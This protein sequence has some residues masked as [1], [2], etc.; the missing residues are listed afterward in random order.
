MHMRP[1]RAKF[2]KGAR[3]FV[4]KD[5]TPGLLLY[6]MKGEPFQI[7]FEKASIQRIRSTLDDLE[8]MLSAG[9]TGLLH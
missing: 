6:P 5:G 3:A 8:A 1:I 9:K 2:I 4:A 7:A